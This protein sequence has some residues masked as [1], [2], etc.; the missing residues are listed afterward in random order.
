MKFVKWTLIVLVGIFVVLQFIRPPKNLAKVPPTADISTIVHV[1][2]DIALILGTSCYDCH[3]STTRYPWYAEVQPV[4]WFLNDH[5]QEAKKELNFSEFATYPLRRQIIK[6]GQV[7]DEV[8]EEKMPLPS[9]L[10]AHS[11]AELS[12][13]QRSRLVGWAMAMQETLKSRYPSDS[14]ERK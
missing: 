8:N 7:G 3:S 4:G 2:D 14:L 9:Y 11:E 13:E 5:I 10:I 1:P 6:L 12:P